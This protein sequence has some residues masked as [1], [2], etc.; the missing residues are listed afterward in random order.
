M[1]VV[2][3][4]DFTPQQLMDVTGAAQRAQAG[5]QDLDDKTSTPGPAVKKKA[6]G[7]KVTTSKAASKKAVKKKAVN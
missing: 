7:N 3:V 1:K 6:A 4:D 5:E 2:A